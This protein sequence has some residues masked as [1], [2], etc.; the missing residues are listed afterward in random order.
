MNFIK[1]DFNKKIFKFNKLRLKDILLNL[2]LLVFSLTMI[3]VEVTYDNK[4]VYSLN[5]LIYKTHAPMLTI[6]KTG[7]WS[8]QIID[9]Y[10][11]IFGFEEEVEVSTVEETPEKVELE[12]EKEYN[13]ID[14]SE[15]LSNRLEVVRKLKKFYGHSHRIEAVLYKGGKCA[16][17]GIKYNGENGAIFDFHHINPKEKDFNISTLFRNCSTIPDKIWRELDKCILVCSNCHRQIHSDKF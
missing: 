1:N 6:N 16:V 3:L 12:K 13:K 7:L 14:S 10:R 2:V 4:G 8:M 5:R 9:L 15:K 17:C 11:Y